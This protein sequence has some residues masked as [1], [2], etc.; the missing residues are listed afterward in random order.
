MDWYYAKGGERH[1]PVTDDELRRLA[2]SH[3]LSG[4][5]L[6]WHPGMDAWK[7]ASEVPGLT[8]PPPIPKHQTADDPEPPPEPHPVQLEPA[9]SPDPS[10]GPALETVGAV[11]TGQADGTLAIEEVVHHPWRRWFARL[12]DIWTWALVFGFVIAYFAPTSPLL[13]SDFVL[14][15]VALIA[16]IF[17]EAALMS[18]PG[19]TLGKLLLNIM[20]DD[21][22]GKP[23][24]F[25]QAMGRSARV[26]L[27][28]LGAGIPIVTLFTMLHQHGKLTRDGNTSWDRDG[29]FVVSYGTVG[30]LRLFAIILLVLGFGYV[31]ALGYAE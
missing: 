8:E 2:E 14:S 11:V 5:D 22:T 9:S 24:L 15:F 1:G 21:P 31:F 13:E 17:V 7:R 26:W 28:G 20:V 12:I 27:Y 4:S 25:S 16:W 10:P 23:L 18:G 3:E 30:G 6:V 19:V 29:G